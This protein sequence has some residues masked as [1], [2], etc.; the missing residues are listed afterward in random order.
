MARQ[1][2]SPAFMGESRGAEVFRR[3]S[4]SPLLGCP[5]V[6]FVGRPLRLPGQG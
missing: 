4:D 5:V 1:N 3:G 6:L 2:F